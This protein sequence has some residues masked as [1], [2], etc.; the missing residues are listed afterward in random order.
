MHPVPVHLIRSWSSNHCIIG[1]IILPFYL[2][3]THISSVIIRAIMLQ[4]GL[5][6]A[7]LPLG[8]YTHSLDAQQK[9]RRCSNMIA[10]YIVHVHG[11]PE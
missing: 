7:D 8:N 5:S 6:A 1:F 9:T 11:T 2:S 4:N 3:F 10:D